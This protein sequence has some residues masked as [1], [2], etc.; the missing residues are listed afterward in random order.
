MPL[1]GNVL[2]LAL[3]VLGVLA[4][5]H[6]FALALDDFAL[7]A[8][9]LNGRSYFHFCLLE[10]LLLFAPPCDPATGQVVGRHLN[11]NL[12][13]GQNADKI[14]PE[15]TGNMREDDMSV[16]DIYLEHCVGKRFHNCTFEFDYI[17]FSQSD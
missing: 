13:T 5:Y 9:G 6:N 4:D 7:F 16:S 3:F 15:L 10:K 14:H 11:C 12:V 17:V 8:H 1:S 2:T